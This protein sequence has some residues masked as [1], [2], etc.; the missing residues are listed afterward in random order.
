MRWFVVGALMM[1][2]AIALGADIQDGR[3]V[4]DKEAKKAENK[5]ELLLESLV[6]KYDPLLSKTVKEL[7]LFEGGPVSLKEKAAMLAE[8]LNSTEKFFALHD[9]LVALLVKEKS[10]KKIIDEE[11]ER[12]KKLRSLLLQLHNSEVKL[13]HALNESA[14]AKN[15]FD[16]INPEKGYRIE[17]SKGKWIAKQVELKSV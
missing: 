6:E 4:Q 1:C 15:R 2:V 3:F 5:K 16:D 9:N 12:G 13:I 10:E 14:K 11:R 17:W 8:S 7:L